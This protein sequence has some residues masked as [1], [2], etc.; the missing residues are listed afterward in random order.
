MKILIN[1]LLHVTMICLSL[2]FLI[3][4]CWMMSTSLKSPEELFLSDIKWIPTH[5]RWLNYIQA[6]Q[7]VNLLNAFKNT[8]FLCLVNVAGVI[9]SSS[10]AAYAFSVLRWKYKNLFFYLTLSTMMLPEMVTLVPQFV[11]F[12]KLGFYGTYLP[13]IAPCLF[14]NAFYIFLFRQFFM[15]IP[16]ELH[17]AASI[18]GSSELLIYFK[19]YMPLS[20]PAISV[21][22]LFQ[23]LATWN[24][25]M[26]SS[27][28]LIDQNQYTLSLA[29][30]QFKAQHGGT[31]WALLMAAS[32]IVVLPIIFIFFIAQKTFVQ[33][34]SMTGIKE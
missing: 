25:L 4:L 26:R 8:L 2:L 19:I 24:D 11:L 32:T 16:Y 5:F 29:L 6:F 1:V 15:T 12:Q 10:L 34:I 20:L 13:L 14:G 30:Q 22:A 23:F 18:D 33:G 3:P 17:E 21:V 9:F 31:E 28:Y 27:I 7:Y